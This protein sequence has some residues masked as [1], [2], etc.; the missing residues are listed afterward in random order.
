MKPLLMAG[1]FLSFSLL[2]PADSFASNAPVKQSAVPTPDT[3]ICSE[4]INVNVSVWQFK[5][6]DLKAQIDMLT[7]LSKLQPSPVF[8]G[9][10]STGGPT[11]I[12][13][14][15]GHT[16]I[17]KIDHL[18]SLQLR[19]EWK[20]VSLSDH[21]LPLAISSAAGNY[22]AVLTINTDLRQP[23]RPQPFSGLV[24]LSLHADAPV[25]GNFE[26]LAIKG[27]VWIGNGSEILNMQPLSDGSY[28]IWI[29]KTSHFG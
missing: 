1:L 10:G 24:R 29:I 22:S 7:S 13:P 26:S 25:N 5:P 9:Q 21:P 27:Q 2:L 4:C 28:I 18:G 23:W 12:A 11:V 17:E 8:Y 19:L 6:S 3:I 14:G 16:F 15:A 20:S